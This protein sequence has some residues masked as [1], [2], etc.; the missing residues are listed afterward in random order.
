M[1]LIDFLGKGDV[2]GHH[3]SV[4]YHELKAVKGK[5]VGA[6]SADGNLIIHGDNLL[7]LRS[8][9]PRYEGRVN[10]IYI[11]PPYNTGFEGWCYNDR[12]NSPLLKTW[13]GKIV[14]SEDQCRHEKWL[15]MMWPRLELLHD[16][17]A[18]DGVIFISI[19]DNEQHRLRAVMDE[20]FG[21]DM[22]LSMFVWQT[23]TAPKGVPP[24]KKL[25][26]NHEYVLC[27]T[28]GEGFSFKGTER[29]TAGFSNP[30]NDSRGPWKAEN[31]KSTLTSA[32]EFTIVD[33][34]TN[35][36]YTKKWGF[37]ESSIKRMIGEGRVI[38][39]KTQSGTPRQKKFLSEYRNKHVPITSYLS[40]YHTETATNRLKEIFGGSKVINFPKPVDLV[41]F[42]IEHST[43]ERSVVLDSFAGSGTTAH[44]VLALNKE[45]GGD[46]KFILVECEDYA[47]K[48]TAERVRRVIKGVSK[49]KDE[50]LKKGLGGQF[51]Y[52]T[53]GD[54]L[55][56][57]K[58]LSGESMP[59]WD[60]LARHVFWLASG[61]TLSKAPRENK[62]GF[63]G[64]SGKG[65]N[66]YLI[67][68]PDLA[69]MQSDKAMLTGDRADDLGVKHRKDGRTIVYAA[70]AYVSQRDMGEAGVLFCQLPWAIT[71]RI[72]GA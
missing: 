43:S 34:A 1:P 9:L 30:D 55:D 21:E 33:P 23:K 29:D 4:P 32:R 3:L 17:L 12:V 16:L 54:E 36:R 19:D 58:I 39:P 10:C 26:S 40:A 46:R 61:E 35:N 37:S 52:M 20:I 18:D 66:I 51:T 27:Y 24:T 72:V 13:H 11:D 2:T 69:F 41:K 28:K 44:A 6:P 22:F 25:I 48:T 47:D 67:Y 31:M 5:S 14:D 8:L 57:D 60:S 62:L 53:L 70:G 50:D 71:K 68:K 59:S 7:A 63:V 49:A 56:P 15:C 45:D 42:F 65:E 64:K 38:F